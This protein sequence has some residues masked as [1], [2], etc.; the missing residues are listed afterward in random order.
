MAPLHYLQN[1]KPLMHSIARSHQSSAPEH[2]LNDPN[3]VEN[4]QK[5]LEK[6]SHLFDQVKEDSLKGLVLIDT[7]QRFGM[8]HYF[9]DQI[10]ESLKQQYQDSQT[11]AYNNEDE[12]YAVSLRFRLLRQQGF[13]VPADVFNSFKGENMKFKY[14]LS[15]DIRGLMALHEASHLS[16]EDEDILDEA[17]IFTT[18]FLTEKLPHLDDRHALIAQNTMHYPYH[19]S[20]ARFTTMNYLKNQDLKNEWEKLLADFAIMDFNL[21]QYIYHEEILQ[22][23]KWWKGLGV[24][25]ELKLARNQPLKWYIWSMAVVKDPCLSKQ[26]IE[27][28]KP[29]SLVYLVDDIFDIYGTLDELI[30]F[31]E[32]INRWEFSAADKLPS[33]MKMCL[34]I[35]HDTTHEISNVV[36]QEFGWS[37]MDYL[38]EAWASLC[39]AFLTEAKWFASGDSPK[40]EE[41]LKNGIIS[42]GVPMVLTNLFFLLGYGESTGTRDIEDIISSVAAILRLLDDLGTAK[43]EEQEGKDGSYVEYYIKEQQDWS[44][45][46][47]RQHVIDMVSQQWKLLNKHCISPTPIPTPFRTACL[48]AAR[49]VPMMYTYNDKH[50]LPVLEE[51]VKFMFSNIME[52]LMW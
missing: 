43:D 10:H 36:Y 30:L 15:E 8:D 19:K 28:T 2:P 4:Q 49:L 11:L 35:I 23:F 37:P 7:M 3:M 14:A 27:I 51:H 9:E 22:V 44:L 17:S 41:Y 32:V 47:G 40:A 1:I 21:V 26:R 42:S 50:R 20:L 18:H 12:L 24:S 33:Y 39:N 6:M 5:Q 48:N 45:G 46:D 31:T 29:I 34:K 52:D 38:K 16:M 25:E 13:H